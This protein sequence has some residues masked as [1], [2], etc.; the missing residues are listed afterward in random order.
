MIR[1]IKEY[2]EYVENADNVRIFI[3]PRDVFPHRHGSTS[4]SF[5]ADLHNIIYKRNPRYSDK[6]TKDYIVA[7]HNPANDGLFRMMKERLI[8]SDS[9][10]YS[11]EE[12]ASLLRHHLSIYSKKDALHE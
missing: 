3:S 10:E 1:F 2:I 6:Y 8:N 11:T 9:L 7:S 12:F 5:I 4:M